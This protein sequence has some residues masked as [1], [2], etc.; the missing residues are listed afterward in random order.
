[1][2]ITIRRSFPLDSQSSELKID[3]SAL[4]V[5]GALSDSKRQ[6]RT[7]LF[8]ALRY[9]ITLARGTAFTGRN[10]TRVFG[11][12]NTIVKIR[13]QLRFSPRDCR[14]WVDQTLARERALGVHHPAKTWFVADT[15]EGPLIGNG[16]PRLSVL[17]L[18]SEHRDGEF[19][20]QTLESLLRL[21]FSAAAA[22]DVRL[23][24]GLSNFGLDDNNQLFYVDDDLYSWDDFTGFAAALGA[25]LRTEP[26]WCNPERIEQLGN[27][28]RES[29][30]EA[31]QDPHQLHVLGRQ[32]GEIHLPSGE[33][34]KA[35]KRIE[36]LLLA[37]HKREPASVP[38]AAPSGVTFSSRFA[39]L[40]DIHANLPALEAVLEDL[41]AR[42]IKEALVLGDVVG[43]GPHPHACIALMRERGFT[44]LQGNHDYGVATGNLQKGFSRLARQAA[45]WTHQQLDDEDLKWL[46]D[47]PPFLRQD[48]WVAVHGAP[49]D[50][51][52]FYGYVYQMTYRDNLDW[53]ENEKV[54]F[55]FH[56]HSHIPGVYQRIKGKDEFVDPSVYDL[57]SADHALL[58]PGSVGQ[59]RSGKP[60]AEY[61][62]IDR[63]TGQ[64]EFVRIEYDLEKVI[65]DI[66]GAGLPGEMANRLKL[67]Q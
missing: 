58:C 44:V 41:D 35:L 55:G 48:D 12:D 25:W 62:V 54:R 31:W 38:A 28:I 63:E 46:G 56:G 17:N 66:N 3:S 5:L 39:L 32:L 30:L 20:F 60:G 53:L 23:D 64:S 33:C 51:Q 24:E 49:I 36:S 10:T 52:F 37:R 6:S 15:S 18:D 14:T 26:S 16:A 57:N 2:I 34:P 9:P 21:Y 8:A 4:D 13:T 19:R 42:N 43:Y 45:S 50:K 47:L 11:D 40:A 65:N 7:A 59:P 61:A 67:G 22:H 27:W 1:M 29:V